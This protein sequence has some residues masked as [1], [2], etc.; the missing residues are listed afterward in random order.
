MV[1]QTNLTTSKK[2]KEGI[3]KGFWGLVHFGLLITVA[4]PPLCIERGK[5]IQRLVVF[6][7][8]ARAWGGYI[9]SKAIY[10]VWVFFLTFRV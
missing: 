6:A 5:E 4:P 2:K 7:S 10:L 3:K 9:I 1:V 8:I